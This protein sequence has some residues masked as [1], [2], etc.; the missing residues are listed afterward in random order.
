MPDGVEMVM[1]PIMVSHK[2]NCSENCMKGHS[3]VME[4]MP[5]GHIRNFQTVSVHKN[6]LLNS[7]T[8][9][10]V[11]LVL[12]ITSFVFSFDVTLPPKFVKSLNHQLL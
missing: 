7:I 10:M 1:L 4:Y 6:Y 8:G 9:C 12:V 5:L 3:W 2:K 11:E